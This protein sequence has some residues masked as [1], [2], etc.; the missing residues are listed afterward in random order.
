MQIDRPLKT[1]SVNTVLL[2]LAVF[3]LFVHV[4]VAADVETLK[5]DAIAEFKKAN[6]HRAIELL[7]QALAEAPNDADVYYYLGYYTHYLCYDSVP[8][9][10][11]GRDREKSDEVLRYLG[12]A[13]EIDPHYGNAYYFIGAEYG[14]RAR[15]GLQQGD[16]GGAAEQFRL[17]REAGGYPDWMIEYGRNLLRSCEPDAILLTWGDAGTNPVQYVQLVSDFRTDVTVVP[18]PLLSR[19]WFVAALKDGIEGG[20]RPAPISWSD[21]QID[22][23]RPYKWK[24]NIIEVIVPE[25]TRKK[26]QVETTVMRWEL[27]PNLGYAEELGLLSADRAVLAD[28]I[29]ANRWQRPICFSADCAPGAYAGLRSHLRLRGMV[30]EL[31]PFESTESVDV[32]ATRRLLLNPDNFRSLPTVRDHDMPRVSHMLQNYRAVY[33]QLAMQYSLSGDVEGVAAVLTVMAENV[34]EDILPISDQLSGVVEKFEQW[35]DEKR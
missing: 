5:Q 29:R 21:E 6:Y 31:L 34:P 28:I 20:V 7:E 33:L 35:L 26:Y 16:A 12:R 3:L 24:T 13:V 18:V 27:E 19:P 25:N 23:M 30:R 15:D 9:T 11:F 14:A 1:V 17:G 8:L 4:P 22:S 10:G 32:E 2:W